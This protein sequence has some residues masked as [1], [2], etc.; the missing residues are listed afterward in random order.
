MNRN[1]FIEAV[2]AFQQQTGRVEGGWAEG[3]PEGAALWAKTFPTAIWV[4]FSDLPH[5][6]GAAP[7]R[8]AVRMVILGVTPTRFVTAGD[9]PVT[10]GSATQLE[11]TPLLAGSL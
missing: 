10:S 7:P 6:L 2:R 4:S 11:R 8:S 1:E 5:A 9:Q 3:T